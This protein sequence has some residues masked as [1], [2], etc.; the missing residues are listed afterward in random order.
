M[1]QLSPEYGPQRDVLTVKVMGSGPRSGGNGPW[2]VLALLIPFLI[3]QVH[4]LIQINRV[5]FGFLRKQ[6]A[7]LPKETVRSQLAG[8]VFLCRIP[9]AKD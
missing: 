9:S 3:R 6:V 8:R 5:M 7:A 2:N 4:I 1:K